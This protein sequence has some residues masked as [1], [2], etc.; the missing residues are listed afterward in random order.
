M[1]F[2]L[3]VTETDHEWKTGG[4]LGRATGRGQRKTAWPYSQCTG[5]AGFELCAIYPGKAEI[6]KAESG[7]RDLST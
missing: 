4:R 1:S 7:Y 3:W 5:W 2:V 6:R